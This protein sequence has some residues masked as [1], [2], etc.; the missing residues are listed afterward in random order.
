MHHPSPGILNPK[1]LTPNLIPQRVR[2]YSVGAIWNAVDGHEDNIRAL[3]TSSGVSALLQLISG[4]SKLAQQW[5]VA[6]L[7]AGC[8]DVSIQQDVFTSRGIPQLLSL[9]NDAPSRY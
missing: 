3:H 1:P 2:E 9:L 5:S 8:G 7:A 6:A 4:P